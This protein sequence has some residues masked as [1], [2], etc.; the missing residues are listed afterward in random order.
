MPDAFSSWILHKF[1]FGLSNQPNSSKLPHF[2]HQVACANTNPR[3][4]ESGFALQSCMYLLSPRKS[5]RGEDSGSEET[6]TGT[7]AHRPQRFHCLVWT[8]LRAFPK[9]TYIIDTSHHQPDS[10]E[11]CDCPANQAAM[12][13]IC[14]ENPSQV[15]WI[16][17]LR[18][19]S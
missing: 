5:P 10:N 17:S 7:T 6:A 9:A 15:F 4:L 1:W 19:P 18:L 12:T 11:T 13:E 3:L 8:H 2:V 16:L 14:Q